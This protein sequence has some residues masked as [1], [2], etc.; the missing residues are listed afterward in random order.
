MTLIS[1]RTLVAFTL[2]CLVPSWPVA[3]HVVA[4]PAQI[5]AG[6]YAAVTFRIGHGCQGGAATTGL[7]INVPEAMLS[8]RPQPKPGWTLTIESASGP[9][10]PKVLAVTW[11]GRLE[12]D[13]F[14]DFAILFKVPAESG[15]LYF[16]ALQTCETGASNWS[17]IPAEPGMTGLDRPAPMVTV[18][19]AASD[20]LHQH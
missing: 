4:V 5:T 7:R 9:D 1:N 19:P 2:L 8:A 17:Q 13:Q 14:D 6:S 15:P 12:D 18:F 16:P 10:K 11:T 20:P 3:A